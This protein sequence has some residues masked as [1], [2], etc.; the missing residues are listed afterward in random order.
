MVKAQTWVKASACR[1]P[2]GVYK[3][4]IETMLD[5]GDVEELWTY[6]PGTEDF[7]KNHIDH[8]LAIVPLEN[9]PGADSITESQAEAMEIFD[10]NS[11][12]A[13]LPKG[14]EAYSLYNDQLIKLKQELVKKVVVDGVDIETAFSDFEAADGVY[15]SEAIVV[16]L[17][18]E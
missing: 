15:M 13:D 14:T 8:V 6:K 12:M 5:G 2:E 3:Y 10:T 4:F 9:D 18:A 17:N 16:S 7:A 1:N 11:V